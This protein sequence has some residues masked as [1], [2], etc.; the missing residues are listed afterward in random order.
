MKALSE[1]AVRQYNELG[2]YAPVPALTPDEAHAIRARLEEF[3]AGAGI[4]AGKLRHKS[5]LLFTW[6]DDL[7][8]LAGI[9]DAVEDVIGPDILCWGSKFTFKEQ[10]NPSFV[11]R[12]QDSTYWGLDPAAS[13]TAWVARSAS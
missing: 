12:P 5:H 1:A 8:R 9:L 6:L 13:A 11:S 3:E 2:Y 4:L 10:R 7:I